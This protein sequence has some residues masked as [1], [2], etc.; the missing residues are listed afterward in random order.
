MQLS[1]N[2]GIGDI[3]DM[4]N[5]FSFMKEILVL[6]PVHVVFGWI[7][8]YTFVV[9]FPMARTI[10]VIYHIDIIM[11]MHLFKFFLDFKST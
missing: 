9:F 10:I 2:D 1:F 7:V 3:M 11:V 6:L 8:Y 4:T 5:F